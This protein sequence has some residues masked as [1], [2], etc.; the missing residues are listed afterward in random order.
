MGETTNASQEN[1]AM[2]E[3]IREMGGGGASDI[4]GVGD[5][6]NKENKT[7]NERRGLGLLKGNR[8]N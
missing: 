7:R 4:G 1:E 2:G 6:E 3:Q 5:K 8:P